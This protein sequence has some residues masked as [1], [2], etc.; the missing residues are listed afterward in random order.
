MTESRKQNVSTGTK[1]GRRTG[2][3]AITTLFYKRQPSY[4][5]DG[6]DRIDR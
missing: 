6:V 3:G 2:D 5:R 1:E 4:N